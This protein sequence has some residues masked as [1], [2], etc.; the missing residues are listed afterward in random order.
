M[1]YTIPTKTDVRISIYDIAGRLIR[2]LVDRKVNAGTHTVL[3]D[4]KN[5]NGIKVPQG[6][7]FYNFVTQI[8]KKTGKITVIR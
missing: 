8:F 6:I 5:K 4:R 2:R 7:Y 3:W 1:V